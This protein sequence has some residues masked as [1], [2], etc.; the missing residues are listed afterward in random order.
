MCGCED[1]RVWVDVKV[2]VDVRVWVDVR[3]RGVRVQVYV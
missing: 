3:V 2:Q 1:V